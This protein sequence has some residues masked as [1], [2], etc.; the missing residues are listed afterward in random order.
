MDSRIVK[1]AEIIVQHSCRLEPGERV[2]IEAFDLPSPD[3]VTEL[4]RQARE[5]GAIPLVQ[6]RNNQILK[7]WVQTADEST[8]EVAAQI[9]AARMR[10]MQAYIGIRA[11]E[12][13]ADFS[14]VAEAALERYQQIY[15]KPVHFEIRVPHTKWCVM[16]YPTPSMAQSANMSTSA[17]TDFFFRV[18]TTDYARMEEAQ[19]PLQRRLEQTERVRIVSPGTDL[20]FSIKNIPVVPCNGR[21]NIPDGEVFTAPVRDS[22]NG[23]ISY[24]IPSRYQGTVFRNIQFTFE[25]GKIVDARCDGE[26]ERLNKILDTDEGARYIGEFSVG[27]NY[28][29][30]QPILDTL[31]DEKIGGSLH[32]T[33][34]NAY[35]TAD[36]GNRSSVHWDLVLGQTVDFGGGELWFDDELIRRD[37]LFIVDDLLALNPG[38]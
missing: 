6:L 33:P 34:G 30:Q 31:F 23:T 29:I 10:E 21:R 18:C 13:S 27:V 8:L 5:A 32:F 4:V 19:K 15:M 3:L 16:R 35:T 9:D 24:N 20:S 26:T 22:V 17:F 37:G 2:L 12:N 38:N 14:D 1:L 36:N 28:E 11:S 7:E 25:H